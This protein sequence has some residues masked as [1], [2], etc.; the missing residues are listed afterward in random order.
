MIYKHINIE[1]LLKYEEDYPPFKGPNHIYVF[2]YVVNMTKSVI[3]MT[4][5]VIWMTKNVIWLTKNV[6]NP[7]NVLIISV[8]GAP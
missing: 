6:V 8:S 3:W 5:S 7:C 1:D 4:K 2:G